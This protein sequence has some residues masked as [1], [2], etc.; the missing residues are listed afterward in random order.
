MLTLV[1]QFPRIVNPI[2][3]S[4]MSVRDEINLKHTFLHTNERNGDS[5][6]FFAE[7]GNQIALISEVQSSAQ[8]SG[9]FKM[10][11][12]DACNPDTD[13]SVGKIIGPIMLTLIFICIA[14]VYCNKAYGPCLGDCLPAWES[15][16]LTCDCTHHLPNCFACSDSPR[17]Y[18]HHRL[19]T[20]S[21]LGKAVCHIIAT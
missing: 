6:V 16:H 19:R 18:R 11:S 7:Q 17:A 21:T 8:P 1:K 15:N 4:E 13:P 2:F 12:H 9:N 14:L 20:P 3:D 5:L 10:L